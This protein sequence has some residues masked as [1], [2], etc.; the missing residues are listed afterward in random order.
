MALGRGLGELLGE[1]QSAYEDNLTH[2]SQNDLVNELDI[3]KIQVN[4]YQPR[5]V[6]DEI[7]LKELSK[8]ILQHGILQPIVVSKKNNNYI[9]IAGERR[10]RAS[11]LASFK[12]IKAIIIDIED[13]KLREYALIENIHRDDLNS[14]ELAYSYKS[15]VDEHDI[16]H[17]E[18][19]SMLQKSRSS[20]SNILRLLNLSQYAQDILSAEKITLGHAKLVISLDEQKQKKV[21]DSVVGQKL[22]VADTVNLINTLKDNKDKQVNKKDNNT[23]D[24]KL[25]LKN[26]TL[27]ANKIKEKN[28]KIK[29]TNKNFNISIN[30]QEDIDKIIQLFK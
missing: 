28:L 7:K 23:V 15:L 9:L 22:S 29:I 30:S 25:D 19:A 8:S 11:K 3:E 5:K 27:L 21:L 24:E 12:T 10:L 18:L 26:L 1:V 14:L 6:F 17:E 4:P 16:T 20:I 13:K 2:D